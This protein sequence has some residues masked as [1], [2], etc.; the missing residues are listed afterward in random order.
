M[1]P[2]WQQGRQPERQPEREAERHAERPYPNEMSG[3]TQKS[4]QSNTIKRSRSRKKVS[5][6]NQARKIS[7]SMQKRSRNDRMGDYWS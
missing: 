1:Q 7:Q 5:E 6:F 4:T 2:G 3:F